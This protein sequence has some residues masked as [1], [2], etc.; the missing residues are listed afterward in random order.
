MAK[1]RALL[2]ENK[3]TQEHQN[4]VLPPQQVL[5]TPTHPKNKIQFKSYLMMLLQDFKKGINKFLKEIQ[6]NIDKQVEVHK[7]EAQKSLKELQE[8]I[9]K[10]AEVIKEER[11]RSLKEV[12]ENTTKQVM[13]LNKNHPRSKNGSRNNK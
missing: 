13:E 2:T 12:Q 7:E 10:Q 9:D 3:T 6:E 11:Q 5:D 4:P 8:N 1:V